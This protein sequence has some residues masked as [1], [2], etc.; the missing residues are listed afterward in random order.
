MITLEGAAG[1]HMIAGQIRGDNAEIPGVLKG[2]DL[3]GVLRNVQVLLVRTTAQSKVTS[4]RAALFELLLQLTRESGIQRFKDFQRGGI[5][6][7]VF[8]TDK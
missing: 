6:R 1:E 5:S 3:K 4:R 7:Y 8:G 2:T